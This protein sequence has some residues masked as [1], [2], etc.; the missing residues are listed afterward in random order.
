M[1][2]TAAAATM[3]G[4]GRWWIDE[5][6]MVTSVVGVVIDG[7]LRIDQAEFDVRRGT[8]GVRVSAYVSGGTIAVA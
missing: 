8:I 2:A 5:V 7:A 6:V 4:V 1:A 3:K